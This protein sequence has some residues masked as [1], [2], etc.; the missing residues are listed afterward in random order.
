MSA[1]KTLSRASAPLKPLSI[2]SGKRIFAMS[3]KLWWSFAR[4]CT[5][6]ILNVPAG[7]F[8]SFVATFDGGWQVGRQSEKML[9]RV[10][11]PALGANVAAADLKLVQ[12]QRPLVTQEVYHGCQATC[13]G[14]FPLAAVSVEDQGSGSLQSSA[15]RARVCP[16]QNCSS[17]FTGWGRQVPGQRLRLDGVAPRGPSSAFQLLMTNFVINE[18]TVNCWC[19][20]VHQKQPLDFFEAYGRAERRTWLLLWKTEAALFLKILVSRLGGPWQQESFRLRLLRSGLLTS[21][22]LHLSLQVQVNG[23]AR[24]MRLHGLGAASRQSNHST[25]RCSKFVAGQSFTRGLLAG[26]ASSSKMSCLQWDSILEK[27]WARKKRMASWASC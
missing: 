15:T 6:M 20:E 17:A 9:Q 2:R 27:N 10:H 13:Q 19:P 11:S 16:K 12:E 3:S 8:T 7:T 23:L 24:K 18:S 5:V 1:S 14:S 25:R 22:A 4:S 26:L 21:L